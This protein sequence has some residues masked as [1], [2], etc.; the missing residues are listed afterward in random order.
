MDYIIFSAFMALALLRIVIMYDIACQW[1]A[2][3]PSRASK[4]P[5]ALQPSHLTKIKTVILSW[6]INGHGK[7]CQETMHVGYLDGVGHLCGDE[8]E[9]TWWSTNI[10][11]T[12]IREMT[13][14]AR[15]EVMSHQWAAFN[16]IKI[17]GFRTRFRPYHFH[18][19]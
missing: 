4:L 15:H 16:I 12:S 11:G 9:Q 5:V 2:N 1:S 17:S 18:T 10:L 3:L 7:K 8:V 13:P 19:N 14:A 6:H